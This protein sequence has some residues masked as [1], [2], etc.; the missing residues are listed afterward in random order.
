MDERGLRELLRRDLTWLFNAT[1]AAVQM[2]LSDYPEVERSVLNYGIPELTGRTL[3]SIRL[4][5]LGQDILEAVKRFEP[6]LLEESVEIEVRKNSVE[7]GTAALCFHI[8]AELYAEPAPLQLRLRTDVDI[9]EGRVA[10]H[11]MMDV[12]K[13]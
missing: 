12:E 1:H 3:S 8:W 13:G 6:R 9:E 4:E 5:R 7:F 11:D 10:V 2:D